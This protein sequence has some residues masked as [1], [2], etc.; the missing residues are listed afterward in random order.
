MIWYFVDTIEKS[1]RSDAGE[2]HAIASPTPPSMNAV[3]MPA[4]MPSSRYRRKVALSGCRRRRRKV[5]PPAIRPPSSSAIRPLPSTLSAPIP[6]PTDSTTTRIQ[7]RRC[8]RRCPGALCRVSTHNDKQHPSSTRSPLAR[9]PHLIET[10]P[11][12]VERYAIR[13]CSVE[14]SLPHAST[15]MMSL[16]YHPESHRHPTN[17]WRS[18]D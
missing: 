8:P 10:R 15:R 5:A 4:T 17:A 11:S 12:F 7:L 13:T 6:H 1:R 9:L 2:G 14:Q 18:R 3:G 16:P